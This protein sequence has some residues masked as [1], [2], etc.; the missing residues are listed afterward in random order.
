MNNKFK[1][2]NAVNLKKILITILFII[3]SVSISCLIVFCGKGNSFLENTQQI[4]TCLISLFGFGL[5]S[6]I[7]IYQ[8]ITNEN[9]NKEKITK[10]VNSLARS[11]SLILILIILSL[12]LDFILNTIEITLVITLCSVLYYSFIIYSFICLIDIMAGLIV[13]I[14]LE[15]DK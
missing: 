6:T 13:I 8:S 1:T 12:L 4:F 9:L 15:K 5:T 2:R 10:L 11:L 3:L 14:K 7:F